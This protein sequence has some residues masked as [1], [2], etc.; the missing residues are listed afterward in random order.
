LFLKQR[1]KQEERTLTKEELADLERQRLEELE[2]GRVVRE[3]GGDDLEDDFQGLAE[4]NTVSGGYA[5]RR[6]RLKAKMRDEDEETVMGMI[7]L[8]MI[9]L[10][11][12]KM[13]LVRWRQGAKLRRQ[14]II[15]SRKSLGI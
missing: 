7:V 13:L 15:H 3:A 1:L 4:L 12:K 11:M 14:E 2:K 10:R 8:K 6:A 5:A 9:V